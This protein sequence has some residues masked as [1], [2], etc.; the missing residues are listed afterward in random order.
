MDLIP[1]CKWVQQQR[2]WLLCENGSF[3]FTRRHYRK[4]ELLRLLSPIMP[5]IVNSIDTIKNN[6]KKKLDIDHYG[7]IIPLKDLELTYR[8]FKYAF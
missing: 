1:A 4:H 6:V 5:V 2:L 8:L 3:F 7:S